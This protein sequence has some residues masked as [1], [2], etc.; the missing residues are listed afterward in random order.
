MQIFQFIDVKKTGKITF[1]Q[2][3]PLSIP[4]N[5]S[6]CSLYCMY[7]WYKLLSMPSLKLLSFSIHVDSKRRGIM[8]ICL[9]TNGSCGNSILA[10]DSGYCGI[11]GAFWADRIWDILSCNL[12]M[13]SFRSAAA[14]HLLCIYL[15]LFCFFLFLLLTANA[16]ESM[17]KLFADQKVLSWSNQLR[18]RDGEM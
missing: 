2:V 14:V 5:E 15:L 10:C 16:P 6:F 17:S 11:S 9:K 8:N 18:S 12:K 4:S 1:K 13:Y 7:S 3:S